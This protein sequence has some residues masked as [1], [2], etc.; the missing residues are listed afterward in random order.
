[1][2]RFVLAGGL[3]TLMS[4]GAFAGSA[5]AVP[6]GHMWGTGHGVFIGQVSSTTFDGSTEFVH[7]HISTA[8]SGVL[9][10]AANEYGA[11]T[12]NTTAQTSS[13]GFTGTISVLTSCG[14]INE[15]IIDSGEGSFAGNVFVG[16]G[17]I[18]GIGTQS[19][20]IDYTQLG[21]NF[22]YSAWWSCPNH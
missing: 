15:A 16:G 1:M 19:L 14:R 9:T 20:E 3:A 12:V 21:S 18:R 7:E 5:S 4:V 11:E 17:E 6:F 2:K 13:W 8:F 22:T 10:G